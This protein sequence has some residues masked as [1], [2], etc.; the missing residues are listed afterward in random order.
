MDKRPLS[1][2]STKWVIIYEGGR[3]SFAG[4]GDL[5]S[6]V[7]NIVGEM[8]GL[9]IGGAVA[10]GFGFMTPYATLVLDI[11]NITGGTLIL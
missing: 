7:V 11:E 4:K 6:I 8:T 10:T 2:P 9:L 5:G 1:R 3:Y